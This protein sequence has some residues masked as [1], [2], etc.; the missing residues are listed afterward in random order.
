MRPKETFQL[1]AKV[2]NKDKEKIDGAT[3]EWTSEN[4]AIAIID[5][6]GI[7]TAKA[8]GTT[9]II[10]SVQNIQNSMEITISSIRKRILS[11]MFTSST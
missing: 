1:R 11:E 3:V 10:A 2:Y 7:L 4:E 9:Y 5:E 6:N 8:N